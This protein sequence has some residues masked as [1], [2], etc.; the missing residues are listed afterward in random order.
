MIRI[1]LM[2]AALVPAASAAAQ[3]IV[4]PPSNRQANYGP[5]CAHAAT[6]TML[7]WQGQPAMATW[8][9]Q[10]HHGA[11]TFGGLAAKAR[12]AGLRYSVLFD[13]DLRILDHATATGRGAVIDWSGRRGGHHA[14]FFCGFDNGMAAIVD[15][16][17]NRLHRFSRDAFLSHWRRCGGRSFMTLYDSS[18]KH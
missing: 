16:N 17:T 11:E 2:L 12:R 8:W 5:S 7:R 3:I 15:P 6:I 4:P 18:P 13:G 14:V 10:T 1:V 9:R